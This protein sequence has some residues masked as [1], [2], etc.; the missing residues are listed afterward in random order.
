MVVRAYVYF[1]YPN[2]QL[3]PN[4]PFMAYRELV[5]LLICLRITVLIRKT[6]LQRMHP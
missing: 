5:A 1:N 4:K 2:K 3:H 6:M